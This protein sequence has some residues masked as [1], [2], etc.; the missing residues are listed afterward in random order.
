[1]EPARRDANGTTMNKDQEILAV[2]RLVFELTTIG[3]A[4]ADLDRLLAKLHGLL[5]TLPGIHVLPHSAILLYNPRRQLIQVAQFGLPAVWELPVQREHA[6]PEAD[7]HIDTA[8]VTTPAAHRPAL[9]L[10]GIDDQAPCFVLPLS[11]DGRQLGQ[12]LLFIAPEWQPDAIEVE[13]MTDLSRALSMLVSRSLMNETLRVREVELEDARTDAIRRLGT[14]S[15][16]RDNETGMHVMRM[17]HFA[18]AIAKAMDLPVETREMLAICAPMHDVGKIGI[19]DAILLK[20]G[21][22][23][24]EEYEVMKTHTEIGERLLGG[25]D[26]LIAAARDIAAYHHE[27][28]DGTG[29]PYGLRGEDIPVLARICSIADVFDALTSIRPYKQPW[30]LEDAIAYLHKESGTHFDPAAVAAFDRALPEIARIRELYRDDIIDPNEVVS[31]PAS[32]YRPDGWV[33][34]DASLSIGI[35]VIDEHHRYLFDLTNDLFDVVQAKR[36][37]R[38][39]AR[40]LKSLDQYTQVHFRAEERMMAHYGYAEQ[41]RQHDQHRAFEEK[42][43]EFYAELHD[44]PLTAQF[45]VLIYLREWL[46]RH[47]RIEDAKLAVLRD[48]A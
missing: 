1:M 11:D 14:A 36:G 26:A 21:R 44:S 8:Y 34:W 19:A 31:L 13:F 28:W 27:R 10:S 47:I 40:V 15:E 30:S 16:Y 9:S 29:Y 33:A 35:D 48:A 12:A 17:T 6:R 18:T 25:N 42:L 37:S 24:P 39:V 32:V 22:L 45:D 46:I 23:T 2:S 20:P 38:E 43:D 41:N 3:Q 5:C 4:D 7:P